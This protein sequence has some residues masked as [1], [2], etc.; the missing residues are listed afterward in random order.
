[1]DQGRLDETL[2]AWTYD[3]SRSIRL[4]LSYT[5]SYGKKV[6]RNSEMEQSGSVDSAILK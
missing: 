1:M 2:D 3:Y 4:T 5:F 6:S